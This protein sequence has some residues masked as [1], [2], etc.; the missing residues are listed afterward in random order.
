MQA[1]A[2]GNRDA[3]VH[4]SAWLVLVGFAMGGLGLFLV[5]PLFG[6]GVILFAGGLIAAVIISVNEAI[7]DR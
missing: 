4:W 2:F 3:S 7:F 5:P 1:P 6:L